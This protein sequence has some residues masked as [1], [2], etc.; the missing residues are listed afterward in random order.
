MRWIFVHAGCA[1]C[2]VLVLHERCTR[3]QYVRSR[4]KAHVYLAQSRS[5]ISIKFRICKPWKWFI[6]FKRVQTQTH[7]L[8]QMERVQHVWFA[9]GWLDIL[10]SSASSSCRLRFN[11]LAP[12]VSAS[13][14]LRGSVDCSPTYTQEQVSFIRLTQVA[15]RC[16]G[17]VAA[18]EIRLV[19][20]VA[21]VAAESA[22]AEAAS[23]ASASVAAI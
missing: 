20:R 5:T 4:N 7:T 8:R 14:F 10:K 19:V 6:I 23:A 9:S 16:R 18:A 22:A 13:R 21:L 15:V 17:G 12:P 11:S 1:A 2:V 3:L